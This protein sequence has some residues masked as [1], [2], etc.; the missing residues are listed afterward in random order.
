MKKMNGADEIT[1]HFFNLNIPMAI[2]T[3]STYQ[4]VEKRKN[5]HQEMFNRMKFVLCGDDGRV[6][7]G[8]PS[9]DMY[10]LAGLS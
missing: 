10:L 4:S 3:S 9:P 7:N 1:N 2:A 6:K 8:K 5:F